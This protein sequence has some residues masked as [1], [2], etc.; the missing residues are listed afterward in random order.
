MRGDGRAL[1]GQ[2]AAAFAGLLQQ[3][4]AEAG[5]TQEE[6]GQ[7]AGLSP[8]TVSDLERGIHRSAHQ[9]TARLLADALGL[10]GPVRGLFAAA[11]RGRVSAAEVLAARSTLPRGVGPSADGQ[12]DL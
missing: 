10:T 1:A 6:L 11:A 7:A 4:R 5:L 2:P 9:D 8:R 3:L 12:A